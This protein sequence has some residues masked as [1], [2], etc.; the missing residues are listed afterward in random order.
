MQT[1]HASILGPADEAF[2]SFV[3]V[4]EESQG[5]LLREISKAA[6]QVFNHILY[7]D[8]RRENLFAL[9][10]LSPEEILKLPKI[11][12]ELRNLLQ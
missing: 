3:E 7:E 11:S 12:Q 1:D 4:L 8:M 2:E 10:T 9:E 6:E 5:S